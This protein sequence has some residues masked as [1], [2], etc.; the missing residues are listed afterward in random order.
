MGYPQPMLTRRRRPRPP[1]RTRPQPVGDIITD[2]FN[3]SHAISG[4]RPTIYQAQRHEARQ[5]FGSSNVAIPGR[6]DIKE[7]ALK[8]DYARK[9]FDYWIKDS[10]KAYQAAGISLFTTPIF[11]KFVR[12]IDTMKSIRAELPAGNAP[13]P[14]YMLPALYASLGEAAITGFAIATTPGDWILIVESLKDSFPDLPDPKDW[15]KYILYGFAGIA[16]ILLLK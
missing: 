8:A 12:N 7:P 13:V 3:N 1:V 14:E 16:A 6:T 11:Q 2:L 4:D 10:F 5:L 9:L 15:G